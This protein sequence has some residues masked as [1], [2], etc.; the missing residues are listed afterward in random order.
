MN[1]LILMIPLALLFAGFFI[2]AFFWAAENGQF[3]D[4]TTPPMRMLVNDHDIKINKLNTEKE[5]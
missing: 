2:Y 5:S 3:D 1:V 4:T